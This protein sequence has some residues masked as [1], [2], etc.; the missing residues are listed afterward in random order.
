MASFIVLIRELIRVM[1]CS[2]A[3]IPVAVLAAV[4]VV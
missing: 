1:A 3:T 4:L 2:F